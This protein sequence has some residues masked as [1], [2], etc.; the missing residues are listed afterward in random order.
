MASKPTTVL[1]CM[2]L[3]WAKV[4]ALIVAKAFWYYFNSKT[5]STFD[6]ALKKKNYRAN[7]A[8]IANWCL[9]M[10]GI[11]ESGMYFY[12]KL[13][14]TLACDERT[15]KALTEHCTLIHVNGKK[16]VDQ[17]IKDEWLKAGDIVTYVDIQHTNIYAGRGKWYDAGHAYCKESGEGAKFET[18]YGPTVYGDQRVAYIISYP[19]RKKIYRVRVGIYKQIANVHNMQTKIRETFGY[20]TFTE[21][22]S[23][24]THVFSGSF[25]AKKEATLRAKQFKDAGIDAKVVSPW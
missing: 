3:M 10:L 23:D 11:F 8:T 15:M 12:G 6:S 1:A 19:K 21:S 13:G 2:K 4:K 5:S 7:C 20:G 9:R 18:W 25:P 14:G 24:G 17:C 22:C 16:T